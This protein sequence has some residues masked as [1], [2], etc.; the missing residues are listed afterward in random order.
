MKQIRLTKK[1][2]REIAEFIN[3]T[4]V[5]SSY[6]PVADAEFEQNGCMIYV[7]YEVYADYIEAED[8]HSE[9]SY[10]QIEDLSCWVACDV[11]LNSICAFS[12]DG[13]QLEVTERDFNAVH[14]A[15]AVA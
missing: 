10:N 6:T 1:T 4:E 14:Q 15:L 3:S 9:V 8:T 7:D 5:K 13:D 2:I 12:E 11:K